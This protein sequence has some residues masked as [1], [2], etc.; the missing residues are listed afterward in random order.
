MIANIMHRNT[1]KHK[2]KRNE[3][4]LN[5]NFHKFEMRTFFKFVMELTSS[6]S[7][8][9]QILARHTGESPAALF[10]LCLKGVRSD[11]ASLLIL[12]I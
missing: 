3:F 6:T 9:I 8:L 5:G 2:K 12:K 1:G 7:K 4:F 10:K 11:L